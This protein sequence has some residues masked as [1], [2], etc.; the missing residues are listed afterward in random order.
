MYQPDLMRKILQ[1]YEVA[2]LY[3]N[4]LLLEKSKKVH[5]LNLTI[6]YS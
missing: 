5:L 2:I 1:F 6:S 4:V 3:A